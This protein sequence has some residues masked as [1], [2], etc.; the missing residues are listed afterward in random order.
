MAFQ[1]K[2]NFNEGI[3]LD[4][5]QLRLPANAALFIKNLT[6]NTNTNQSAPSLSGQNA[7]V[8]TPI[9]GNVELAITLP[10]GINYCIGFYSSEQTNEG[11]FFI[12]SSANN[13]SIWVISGDTGIATK[14]YQGSCLNFKL[15]P[16]YFISAGRCIMEVLNYISPV[17]GLETQ[18]KF[19][20][21]TDNFN[22]QRQISVEDS[23]NTNSFT[24]STSGYF[25]F[26][27]GVDQ[28]ICNFINLPIAPP[29]KTIGIANVA[30]DPTVDAKKQNK[31]LNR[32]F[33]FRV[34]FI[35]VFNQQSEHGIISDRYITLFGSSCLQASSG[36]PR[37]VNLTFDAGNPF[38]NKI[39]IEYRTCYANDGITTD[40]IWYLYDVIDNWDN[41]MS[42]EWYNRNRNPSITY[43]NTTNVITYEFDGTK[44]SLPISPTET[45]RLYN[46]IPL[47][48]S[49]LFAIG[50]TLA[51]A[52][53]VRDF[54][55]LNPAQLAK[56]NITVTPPPMDPCGTPHSVN[57]AVYAVIYN[58]YSSE[59]FYGK[60]WGY[61]HGIW[62][63]G[64]NQY[65][66][67][68]LRFQTTAQNDGF[69]FLGQQLINNGWI[70][71]LAGTPYSA[72]SVQV[73]YNFST[74]TEAAWDP[75]VP[76]PAGSIILQ[77]WT[78]KVL[79]GK[80]VFRISGNKTIQTDNYSATS[81]TVWG[82]VNLSDFT[83]PA[84]DPG[85]TTITPIDKIRETIVDV[86]AGTDIVLRDQPLV[87]YD[88][89]SWQPGATVDDYAYT[90]SLIEG[91]VRE[92]DISKIPFE[93]AKVTADTVVTLPGG[94]IVTPFADH[95]GFF[96]GASDMTNPTDSSYVV[97]PYY[98]KL[99][100]LVHIDDCTATDL[101]RRVTMAGIP[102]DLPPASQNAQ[103]AIAVASN[104]CYNSWILYGY[105][106]V[107]PFITNPNEWPE[108]GR[109]RLIGRIY[110]CGVVATGIPGIPL[111]VEQG[112]FGTTDSAG[113]WNLIV[114]NRYDS[115]A[116]ANDIIIQ[117][118]GNCWV[119][120]C[121]GMC[122]SC[123]ADLTAAYIGCGGASTGCVPPQPT[124]RAHCFG[125]TQATIRG[126]NLSGPQMG[127]TYGCGIT[128]YD[129]Y[130]R[131]GFVQQEDLFYI[132]IPNLLETKT[133]NFSTIEF[134]IGSSIIFPSWVRYVSFYITVNTNFSNFF[135][136]PID[137]VEFVDGAGN[138]NNAN[139]VYVRLFY[140][141]LNQYNKINNFSTNTQWDFITVGDNTQDPGLT[142]NPGTP[143]E[144]DVI[145][146]YQ[147]GDGVWFPD[148]VQSLVRYDLTGS[149]IEVDYSA[150]LALLVSGT[151]PTGQGALIRVIRPRDNT[152]INS[153]YYEMNPIINV[154]SGVPQTLS[155]TF[156]YFDS[157]LLNRVIPIPVP[158]PSE[159]AA[160]QAALPAGSPTIIPAVFQTVYP[161]LYEGP[162]PS[163]F[164]GYDCF[165]RGRINEKNPYERQ[166]R[167]G[168][169]IA[170]SASLLTNSNFNG[171]SYFGLTT[172]AIFPSQ[173]WGNITVV[174]AETGIC[175][176]ICDSNH[177]FIRFQNSQLQVDQNGNVITQTPYGDFTAPERKP[178]EV[179]G[180]IPQNI[181]TIQ[182]YS[183]RVVWLDAKGH[184]IFSNFGEST[185]ME[186]TNGYEGYL[187]NKIATINISNLA[188]I[189]NGL[190]YPIGA[191]DPK[192]MEYLLGSLNIPATGAPSYINTQS[193]PNL[194][195]NETL[196]FDLMTGRLKSFASFTPEYYGMIPGYYLQKQFLSFKNGIPYLHHNTFA[197]GL[198]PPA[199]CLFYGVPCE[200]RI[201]H[202]VNGVDGKQLP[203]KVKRFLWTEIFC[204]QNVP[205]ASGVMPSALFFA[206]VINTEKGQTSRLL[207]ARWDLRDGYQ[208]AAF[209]CASNTPPDPNNVPATT[210]NAILDGDP[211]QGRWVEVSLT[212]NPS[213]DHTYFEISES[214]VYINGVEKTPE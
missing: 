194:N 71:Y 118:Q 51:V 7:K 88:F 61:V 46:P 145:E 92:D 128:M 135:T 102:P 96:F 23:I 211:L 91:Y 60:D 207:V 208:T 183:G 113:N 148:I 80:Y 193:Q 162:A 205:G 166:K 114:H 167:N 39:Q 56:I 201:T 37:R 173:E 87:I 20:I 29:L 22:P 202:V 30:F 138:I 188:P 47:T 160:E 197:G 24:S 44:E 146:F 38:V 176:V 75:S 64:S 49:G 123:F 97:V 28:N 177:F 43:N 103:T 104:F 3:I 171:L 210:T 69:G 186:K 159:I 142:N 168:M 105:G 26:N 203:D 31:L 154:I 65:Y 33:Q 192:T 189:T 58:Q 134:T 76:I 10:S 164:W 157:F 13:H 137:K 11:Y 82:H 119:I 191:I 199:Y 117:S 16:R 126:L 32:T 131:A 152:N 74:G 68:G 110:L 83:P 132:T 57:V 98:E 99:Q 174:L 122:V 45:D 187:L 185:P 212:N 93:L 21:F 73:A 90:T 63:Y 52:N 196:I 156:D 42:V 115:F 127:G 214:V 112:P 18:R 19:L 209:I 5:D 178:G 198:T 125:A 78:F 165:N 12:Y 85:N 124:T 66:P 67:F 35:N 79:P 1:F 106:N 100:L 54:E 9:E 4:L 163:D 6:D 182:K 190:T 72:L 95:N 120:D 8:R 55:P 172:P 143:V 111:V 184:L 27:G 149:Y 150:D 2:N 151:N 206:D 70:G 48:S 136:W 40:S 108:G 89:L 77:K 180:C 155:G 109:R 213:W 41:S 121:S 181:N 101:D 204:R 147:N 53:N 15:D 139:P 140:G 25:N 86:C 144:G 34:K 116:S 179:Y 50:D 200:V 107:D 133:F 129:V 161:Y 17:T 175:M 153:V 130:G 81:T 84:Y 170:Q 195:V 14:V 36:N 94:I 62:H 158:Q 169:E 59:T 141:S